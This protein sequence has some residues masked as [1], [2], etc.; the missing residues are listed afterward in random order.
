MESRAYRIAV[1][2]SRHPVEEQYFLFLPISLVLAVFTDGIVD[3]AVET[4][5]GSHIPAICCSHAVALT[6]NDNHAINIFNTTSSTFVFYPLL[7]VMT[8]ISQF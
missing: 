8:L 4:R 7:N 6:T 3:L 2:S 5:D 1:Q